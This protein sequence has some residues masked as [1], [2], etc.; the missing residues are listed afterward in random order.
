MERI[1][2]IA[3]ILAWV[4]ASINLAIQTFPKKETNSSNDEKSNI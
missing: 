1:K 2:Y 4:L 3:A